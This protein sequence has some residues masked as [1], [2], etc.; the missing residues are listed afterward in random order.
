MVGYWSPSSPVRTTNPDVLVTSYVKSGRTLLSIASWAPAPVSCMLTI[1]WQKIGLDPGQVVMRAP[2][3]A[4][5]QDERVVHPGDSITVDPG[6]GV[7][8]ILEETHH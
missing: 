8:L 4:G 7:L 5:F 1:D 2:G 3:S 6:K